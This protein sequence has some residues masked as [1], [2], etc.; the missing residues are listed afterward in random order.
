[1]GWILPEMV[2]IMLYLMLVGGSQYGDWRGDGMTGGLCRA[3][4]RAFL[5]RLSV[6]L[7]AR[8]AGGAAAPSAA[9]RGRHLVTRWPSCLSVRRSRAAG[10][11]RPGKGGA[12]GPP[13][14]CHTRVFEGP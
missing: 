10:F 14:G 11:L 13:R 8:Y 4:M 7:R 3:R 1:M 5:A 12:G 6:V 9:A 2:A